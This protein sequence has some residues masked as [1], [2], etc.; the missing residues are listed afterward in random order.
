MLR[1]AVARWSGPT[2]GGAIAGSLGDLL[3]CDR[4]IV[5]AAVAGIVHQPALSLLLLDGHLHRHV[6]HVV[7]LRGV[8]VLVAAG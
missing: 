2:R 3:G 7:A 8:G 4:T 1:A 6:G 5:A